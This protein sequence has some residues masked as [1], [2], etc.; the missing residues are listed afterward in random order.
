MRPS[1]CLYLSINSDQVIDLNINL[2]DLKLPPSWSSDII[3]YSLILHTFRSQN[4][5]TSNA[6]DYRYGH[7]LTCDVA[8]LND[9]RAT[10]IF[11]KK[12][13]TSDNII[14]FMK[15]NFIIII[16]AAEFGLDKGFDEQH[17]S[18]LIKSARNISKHSNT[19]IVRLLLQRSLNCN[20]N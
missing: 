16:Q 12:T 6:I 11:D 15:L 13:A 5:P 19:Y 7:G 2:T 4:L 20:M 1:L 18:I 10:A 14:K 3:L 8:I 9:D 17:A